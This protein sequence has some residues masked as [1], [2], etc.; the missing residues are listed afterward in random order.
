MPPVIASRGL[1]PNFFSDKENIWADNAASSRFFGNVYVCWTQFHG[2]SPTAIEPIVISRSTNGGKNWSLPVR[3]SPAVHTTQNTGVQ[4]C[5]I[6]TD[7]KGVV[8]VFWSNARSTRGGMQMMARS[9]NGGRTFTRQKPV[10]RFVNVGRIDPL[11]GTFS[12]DGVAGARTDPFPGVDIAN[13]APAG[14]DATDSI[15]LTWADGRRGLNHERALV[16]VSTTRGFKWSKPVNAAEPGDRPD[17]P[18]VGVTPNGRKAFFTYDAFLDPWQFGTGQPRRMQGVVRSADVGAGKLTAFR[19]LH[20]GQIGDAR[21]SSANSL[22]TEFIGD[23]NYAA[24]LRPW[25]GVAVWNDVRDA[26]LCP[27]VNSF[28]QSLLT[29]HPLPAPWPKEDCPAQFGN[30]DIF[31]GRFTSPPGN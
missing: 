16:R 4:G 3:L 2:L 5:T 6:R 15:F 13:G 21:A 26:A 20:R 8:Y 31:G 10:A 19:T 27:A 1:K 23:Y 11:Q 7:S 14:R 25:G 28:R 24:G 9:F 29:Q 22:T 17:F 30:T 18:A 12:F